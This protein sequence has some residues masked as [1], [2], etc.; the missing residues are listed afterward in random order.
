MKRFLAGFLVSV[1]L[2]T[3]QPPSLFSEISA[4]EDGLAGITGLPFRSHVPSALINKEQ[5]RRDFEKR[6]RE[7]TKPADVRAEEITLKMLGLVPADFNLR[8]NTIDLLTEQAA[9]FYDYDKKKLFVI[10]DGQSDAEEKVALVHELAHALADQHFQLGKFI[11]EGLQNDDGSTARLAVM[12]GQATW[13]MAAFVSNTAGVDGVPAAVLDLMT[14][15][16]ESSASDYPVFSQQPPYMRESLV[17]PYA[18]GMIFQN[19]VYKKLGRMSF[20]EVFQRPPVSTQQILHPELYLEHR[21]PTLPALPEIPRAKD[22]RRLGEG[23][24]GELEYRVLLTQYGEAEEGPRLAAR[25]RG[26]SY[27]L[28]ESKKERSPILVYA[29]TWESEEAAQQYFAQALRILQ[30]KWKKIDIHLE[31]PAR[32]EGRGDTGYFRIWREAASVYHLEGWKSAL[33]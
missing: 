28:L 2:T 12:E 33:P 25:L 1:L 15:S 22:F 20:A 31:T 7:S 19:E 26:S 30:G 11:R 14:Q 3:A 18:R 10:D 9:A 24:L 6:I 32:V 5:L 21:A 29:S 8:Q 13:L 17:F 4:I 23:T 16:I 27:A